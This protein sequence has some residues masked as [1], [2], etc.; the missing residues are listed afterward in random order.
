[1]SIDS[2]TDLYCVIGYPVR[3]SFSPLLHNECF[4]HYNLNAVY[5]AFEIS[6]HALGDF[7][8]TMKTL[9]IKGANITL[10][11]KIESLKYV[12]EIDKV[13]KDIG[14]INTVKNQNGSLLGFNTDKDGILMGLKDL[15]IKIKESNFLILGAG[16]AARTCVYSLSY[17]NAKGIFI[18]NRT[19]E[20]G[21]KLADELN[22]KFSVSIKAV[23]LENNELESIINKIDCIINAT[24]VGIKEDDPLIIDEKLLKPNIKVYD[25]TYNKKGTPLVKKAKEKG[26]NAIDGITMLIYQAISSFK[27]WTKIEPEYETM[28]QAIPIRLLNAY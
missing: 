6:P 4:K 26:L 15:N 1:M 23:A 18:A 3:H 8:Q 5:L 21:E 9:N 10:P 13:A 12:D 7:F 25:L 17:E 28:E 22:E 2:N 11:H 14:A 16:G 19:Y 20:K 27:I 24:S